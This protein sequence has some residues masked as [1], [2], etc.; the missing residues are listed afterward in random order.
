M[1]LGQYNAKQPGVYPCLTLAFDKLPEALQKGSKT[2]V[3]KK[4]GAMVLFLDAVEE[5]GTG[6]LRVHTSSGVVLASSI[7]SMAD[8]QAVARLCRSVTEAGRRCLLRGGR[9]LTYCPS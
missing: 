9:L 2:L 6:G 8:E 4:G 7:T 1:W 3:K 5:K